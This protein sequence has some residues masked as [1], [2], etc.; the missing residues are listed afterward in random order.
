[1]AKEYIAA[2]D[3][4]DPGSLVLSRTAGAAEELDAA[5]LVNPFVPSDIA[6]GIRQAL[7][8]PLAERRRRHAILRARVLMATADD[9]SR[10][11][12]ADLSAT[13]LRPPL[14]VTAP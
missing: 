13:P 8:S 10:R 1:V 12:L 11:L 14:E 6:R 5:I 2:Q 4:L 3:P 7:E 9:W